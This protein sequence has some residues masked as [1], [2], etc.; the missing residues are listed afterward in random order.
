MKAMKSSPL[1]KRKRSSIVPKKKKNKHCP[2]TT[3]R[4]EADAEKFGGT[5]KQWAEDREY[6]KLQRQN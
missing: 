3:I 5:S 4:D 1:R 2:E 6:E